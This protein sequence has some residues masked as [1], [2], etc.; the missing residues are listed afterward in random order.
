MQPYEFHQEYYIE[1]YSRNSYQELVTDGIFEFNVVPCNDETQILIDSEI[2]Q[3]LS[4]SV[5]KQT[6]LFG[7]STLR[8]RSSNGFHE[9]SFLFKARIQKLKVKIA[10]IPALPLSEEL[11]EITS[12]QFYIDH[13]L[14]LRA[15]PFA[16]FHEHQLAKV[17]Q[18]QKDCSPLDFLKTLN[19]FVYKSMKYQK[20][21]T[22]EHTCL[23]CV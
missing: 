3:T 13:H 4:E 21:I 14:F 22:S 1:Y 2:K 20:D 11:K 16:V 5:F 6:N 8:I 17:P 18:Y 23:R 15:S 12:D 10:G 9:F 19:S 7:F